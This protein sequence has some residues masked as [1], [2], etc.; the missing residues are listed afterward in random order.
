MTVGGDAV[1]VG[2]LIRVAGLQVGD[3]FRGVDGHEYR[4]LTTPKFTTHNIVV[5]VEVTPRG[6]GA[7]QRMTDALF[8]HS[9]GETRVLLARNRSVQAVAVQTPAS[10]A[11]A[12]AAP[13]V[14]ATRHA[15]DGCETAIGHVRSIGRDEASVG[16]DDPTGDD[17]AADVRRGGR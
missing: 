12:K 17:V 7:K 2:G 14:K 1:V 13:A 3:V 5:N 4:V 9:R 16:Y 6:G 8:S 11:A 15:A 10:P